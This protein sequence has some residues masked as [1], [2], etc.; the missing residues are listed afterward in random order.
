M[1]KPNQVEANKNNPPKNVH[2]NLHFNCSVPMA[3]KEKKISKHMILYS[4]Y[5]Q[6][7]NQNE[8]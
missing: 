7:M 6:A 3:E 5:L 8:W 2:V 1:C 4:E